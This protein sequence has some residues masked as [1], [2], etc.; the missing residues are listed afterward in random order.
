[1]IHITLPTQYSTFS[2]G[3]QGSVFWVGDAQPIVSRV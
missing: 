3:R 2:A 1:M